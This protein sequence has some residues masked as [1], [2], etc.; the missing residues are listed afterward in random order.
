MEYSK[1]TIIE[2][3]EHSKVWSTR[4]RKPRMKSKNTRKIAADDLRKEELL[5]ESI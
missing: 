1:Q 4:L 2:G 5:T 3:L